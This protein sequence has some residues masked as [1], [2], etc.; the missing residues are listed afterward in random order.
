M[1]R[2]GFDSKNTK[3]N[4]PSLAV[5]V[6]ALSV[7]IILGTRGLFIKCTSKCS[8]ADLLTLFGIMQLKLFQDYLVE[9]D[10]SNRLLEKPIVSQ[11]DHQMGSF[12]SKRVQSKV[13]NV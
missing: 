3:I 2:P 7:L 10:D 12:S 8:P 13:R 9:F 11:P 6:F 1:D 5:A 4:L